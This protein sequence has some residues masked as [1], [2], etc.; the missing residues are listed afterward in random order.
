MIMSDI[1][2]PLLTYDADVVGFDATLNNILS[3]LMLL[4]KIY[5][6]LIARLSVEQFSLND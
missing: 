2:H 1:S 4:V 3:M 6:L 5:I